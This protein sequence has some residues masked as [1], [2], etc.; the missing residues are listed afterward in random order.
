MRL[1]LVAEALETL[2]ELLEAADPG[3]KKICGWCQKFLG[4]NP[5][6]TKLS[7]G[8]CDPCLERVI[9][10]LPPELQAQARAKFEA[11]RKKQQP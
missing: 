3:F 11:L 10:E 7:H 2:A 8:I 5:Q 1:K 9:S 4:G 6:G